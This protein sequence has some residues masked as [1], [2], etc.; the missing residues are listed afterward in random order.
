MCGDSLEQS[1]DR[2]FHRARSL[3]TALAGDDEYAD[4]GFRDDEDVALRT[5]HAELD[6]LPSALGL[7]E[8]L[9]LIE[10]K[11]SVVDRRVCMRVGNR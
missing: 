11:D 3:V 4:T 8:L 10:H 7:N 6:E 1:V 5:G 2:G 9:G